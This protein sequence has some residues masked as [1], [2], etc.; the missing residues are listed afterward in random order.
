MNST[1]AATLPAADTLAASLLLSIALRRHV[2]MS[3][4]TD[5]A[6][7]WRSALDNLRALDWIIEEDADGAAHLADV[8]PPPGW[9]NYQAYC[10]GSVLSKSRYWMDILR[11]ETLPRLGCYAQSAGRFVSAV[12]AQPASDPAAGDAYI[13][14]AIAEAQQVRA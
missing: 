6:A 7:D 2:K 9:L 14:G 11:D 12:L 4:L 8:D 1:P 3:D 5:S 13:A 10:R